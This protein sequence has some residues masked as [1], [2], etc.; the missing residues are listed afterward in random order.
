[1][2]ELSTAV[3]A[4]RLAITDTDIDKHTAKL[5]RDAAAGRAGLA[6]GEVNWWNK[7]RARDWTREQVLEAL[8]ER[9]RQRAAQH[10]DWC[11]SGE[12]LIDRATPVVR[13]GYHWQHRPWNTLIVVACRD[14][15]EQ[16]IAAALI[17]QEDSPYPR[18]ESSIIADRLHEGRYQDTYGS[19]K[20]VVTEPCGTCARPVTYADPA[21]SWYVACSDQCR[22]TQWQAHGGG[23]PKEVLEQPCAHCDTKYTPTR[24]DS[25]YCSN[26]CRQAAYRARSSAPTTPTP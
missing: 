15:F 3:L 25:H 26:K 8:V 18:R 16:S 12:H 9:R 24:T 21:R 19:P 22:K 17:D 20:A 1:M 11:I 14:C 7:H 13:I 23:P 5:E 6:A 10:G 4:E 2:T